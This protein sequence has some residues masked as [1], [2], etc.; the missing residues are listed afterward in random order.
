MQTK[1]S[2]YADDQMQSDLERYYPRQ[3]HNQLFELNVSKSVENCMAGQQR[4]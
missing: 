3:Q 2:G 1:D 4:H